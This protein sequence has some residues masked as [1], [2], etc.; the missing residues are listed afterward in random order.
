[1]PSQFSV[2]EIAAVERHLYEGSFYDFVQT[3]WCE[4]DPAPYKDNWHVEVLCDH[5]Q[6]VA[7]GRI[8]RLLINVPPGSGKSLISNVL[9][10]AWLWTH[11]PEKSIISTSHNQALAIRDS[12]RTRRLIRSPWFQALWSRK[13]RHDQSAKLSF[14]N[15]FGGVRQASPLGSMTGNR[16]N[17]VIVDDPHSRDSAQ[18]AV[19]RAAAVETFLES[20]PSRLNDPEND[21]IIVIMQ[22]LHRDDVTGAILDRPDLGYTHLCI[23]LYAD[24][25]DRPATSIGWKDHR[26]EGVNIFPDHYTEDAVLGFRTSLGPFAFSGQYQQNPIPSTDGFFKREWFHRY[27]PERL[28]ENLLFYMTSDHAPSGSGD[29][30]V[31]RMWGVDHNRNLWLVDSFREKCTM[32]AVIGVKR[33]PKTGKINL[34]PTG[35]ISMIRKWKPLAWYPEND[36]A[37]VTT[38]SFLETAMLDTDTFVYLDPLPS[39]GSGDKVGKAQ[40]YQAMA[41]AGLIHLPEGEIGDEALL[42]YVAF[43]AGRHDDQVDADGALPR[44]IARAQPSF[45]APISETVEMPDPWKPRQWTDSDAAWC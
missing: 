33:D 10:P 40:C 30:N 4:V 19:K 24:G 11:S 3:A 6:A 12:T 15:H 29:Y 1:M 36:V 31:I 26:A 16:G 44:V 21:A 43:P 7:D 42:E 14:A 34:L 2:A 13:I 9:F 27:K 17:V 25:V 45:L 39:K 32:D 20:I 41:S 22:R 5:L 23:P 38:R 35:A 37:W 8:K 18:S 28:P